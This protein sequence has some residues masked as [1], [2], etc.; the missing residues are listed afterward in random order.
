MRIV[1]V[2]LL[3]SLMVC[4]PLIAQE[5]TGGIN[6]TVRDETGGVIPGVE[7]SVTNAAHRQPSEYRDWR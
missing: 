1:S 6:G 2:V 3:A 7:V 4:L 5:S